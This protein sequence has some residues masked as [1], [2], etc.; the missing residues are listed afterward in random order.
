M[1]FLNRVLE[2]FKIPKHFYGVKGAVKTLSQKKPVC[3]LTD[4]F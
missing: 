3:Q 1:R 4:R 2:V